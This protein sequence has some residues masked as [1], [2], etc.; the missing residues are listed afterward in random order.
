MKY[1]SI[2]LIL[3]AVALAALFLIKESDALLLHRG[4]YRRILDRSF[5]DSEREGVIFLKRR[6][7]LVLLLL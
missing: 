1:I 7:A 6:R 2:V 4:C 3:I 5:P